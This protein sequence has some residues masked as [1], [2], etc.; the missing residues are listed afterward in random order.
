MFPPADSSSA[1][2][3]VCFRIVLKLKDQQFFA[4]FL[5]QSAR[6]VAVASRRDQRGSGRGRL[7]NRSSTC[8]FWRSLGHDL[9]IQARTVMTI[10]ILGE[11]RLIAPHSAT[12][13]VGW[14][15]AAG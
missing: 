6:S 7:G 10:G 9:A 5:A 8:C 2:S 12:E 1:Y 14:L 3:R 15:I 4:W 13:F 11:R